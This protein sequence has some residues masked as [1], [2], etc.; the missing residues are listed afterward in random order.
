MERRSDYLD[1]ANDIRQSKKYRHLSLDT[2]YRIVEWAGARFKA[3]EINKNARKKLH[4]VYGAYTESFDLATFARKLEEL[5][6]SG[7]RLGFAEILL[8]H[9]SS[10]ERVG[11]LSDFYQRI[12]EITGRPT[13][14]ID[15][16]CGLNPFSYPWIHD[17]EAHLSYKGFDIDLG[18]TE[19]MEAFFGTTNYPVT[20]GY[21]D[22]FSG[23]PK[24]D[25]SDLV[26]LLKTLPCL[27]QQ[28]K[29]ISRQLLNA[30]KSKKIVVSFPA[31][32]LGGKQKGMVANYRQ[33]LQDCLEGE[34]FAIQEIFF[35]TETVYILERKA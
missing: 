8:L 29:G 35:P 12:F 14:I 11:L 9:S 17:S 31:Q 15:L 24:H 13:S 26:M 28:E 27:E 19:S 1:I 7:D 10:K 30:I 23:L 33:W 32:S 34:A 5:Q 18:T 25:E 3:K 20:I 16:A 21:N 2:V 6:K 22:L 4:Q